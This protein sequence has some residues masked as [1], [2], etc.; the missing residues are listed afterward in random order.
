MR[1][2]FRTIAS[3]GVLMAGTVAAPALAQ[4]PAATSKYAECP[5]GFQASQGDQDAAHGAFLAGKAAYDEAD[6]QKAIDY[7]KDAYR[8]E[9]TK[10]AVLNFIARAYEAKG[11][12]P[13][14]V[15]ALETYVQR[16]PKADDAEAV[17]KRIENLKAAIA[18]QTAAAAAA[19]PKPAATPDPQ[20]V[21]GAPAPASGGH[22]LAPWITVGVGGAA[23]AAGVVR[24][25]GGASNLSSARAG[26]TIV[27]GVYTTCSDGRPLSAHQTDSNSASSLATIGGVVAGVGAAA[28]IGGLVWHFVEPTAAKKAAFVPMFS[29]SFAGAGVSGSF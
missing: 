22:S 12:K 29:P 23:L 11:D 24:G 17:K 9:C 28:V 10:H 26:C 4:Q 16:A 2:P 19:P 7:F 13:E 21:A 3:F 5:A 18:A 20:P 15:N 14:A 1:A 27:N 25:G 6:Y 8:R